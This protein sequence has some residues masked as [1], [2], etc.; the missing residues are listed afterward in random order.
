MEDIKKIQEFFSKDVNEANNDYF[1]PFEVK[2]ETP[3]FKVY[4]IKYPTGEG[5]L[6]IGGKDTSSGQERRKG[7]TQAYMIGQDLLD[8]MMAQYNLEDFEVT[9]L[10]NGTVEVFMVSDEFMDG[11]TEA[12]LNDPVMMKMRAAK[13]KLAKMR[14]ANAGGDGNDKFFKNSTKLATLEKGRRD[15]M[16]DMEQEAEPEGGPIANEYGRKLNRIDA[17]IAKLSG[18]KEMDYDTAVGKVDEGNLDPKETASLEQEGRFWVVTYRTMDGK[19]SRPFQ[20]K[21]EAEKFFN[22]VYLDESFDSLTKKLDKQKGIDKEEAEK[23][24]GAIA[25]KKMKGAGK[26]PTTKQLK[27][28]KE[29]EGYS[30]QLV[31]K[32]NPKG[33]TK[34]LDSKTMNN[35]LMNVIKDLDELKQLGEGMIEEEL[36]AKGKAYRKKRMAAGEKSSAYLS[37]RAVKVCKGDMKG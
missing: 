15:L 30:P 1:F 23:I 35:I 25:A 12:D 34:G 10:G 5:T 32:E 21:D 17:A 9:D 13:S 2:S 16:R 28:L 27:R 33:K 18:R 26:G 8:D 36:C 14:K 19:K 31:S 20:S 7:A 11:I 24:A 22:T 4:H 37:G 3:N 6:S 29:E